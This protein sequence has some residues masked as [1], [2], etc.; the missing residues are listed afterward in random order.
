MKDTF[1][2]ALQSA[3]KSMKHYL[4]GT[5]NTPNSTNEQTKSES[6]SKVISEP[7]PNTPFRIVHQPEHGWFISFGRN[8]IT[9]QFYKTREEAEQLVKE[10]DWNLMGVMMAAIAEAT[11]EAQKTNKTNQQ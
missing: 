1:T 9:E 11:I 2:S 5:S 6:S 8:R 3:T 7:I 4:M 10:H